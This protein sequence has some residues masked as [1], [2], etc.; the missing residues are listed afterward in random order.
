MSSNHLTEGDGRRPH[1]RVVVSHLVG[2][3]RSVLSNILSEGDIV[4]LPSEFCNEDR[5]VGSPN[6]GFMGGPLVGY[7]PAM[8]V[9]EPY[10]GV[11]TGVVY[12]A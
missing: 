12:F 1:S 2:N 3:I 6:K 9:H 4:V 11:D 10:A 8:C 5:S 7:T